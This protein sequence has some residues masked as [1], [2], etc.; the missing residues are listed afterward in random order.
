MNLCPISLALVLITFAVQCLEPSK[1]NFKDY[2]L[3]YKENK[4]H[5][6]Q[7]QSSKYNPMNSYLSR[8]G[9]E[10]AV[11]RTQEALVRLHR[12]VS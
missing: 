7:K 6:Q 5:F 11:R 2:P 8:G 4:T 12:P 3:F 10:A 9:Q 1:I